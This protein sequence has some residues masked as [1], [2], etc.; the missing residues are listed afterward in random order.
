M[1]FDRIQKFYNEGL[2]SIEMVQDGVNVGV[3]TPA[4]YYTITKDKEY[5][6]TLVG[7]GKLTPEEYFGITGEEYT[8]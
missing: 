8:V 4:Q 7:Q 2:W 6:K 3:I 5:L 1:W